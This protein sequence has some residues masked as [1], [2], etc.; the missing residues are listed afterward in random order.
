[1]RRFRHRQG[2]RKFRGGH[3]AGARISRFTIHAPR[4]YLRGEPLA[5]PHH[6]SGGA[7]EAPLAPGTSF[8]R[9]DV[10]RVLGF[11]GMGVVYEALH[12]E[13][14]KRLALKVMRAELAKKAEARVRFVREGEAAARIRHP[15]V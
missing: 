11:G 3:E 15:H 5:N 14:R 10:V 4:V 2:R 6:S 9:Y 12:R 7:D 8:G 1:M 13:L